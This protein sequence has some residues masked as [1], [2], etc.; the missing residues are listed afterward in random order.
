MGAIEDFLKIAAQP[1]FKGWSLV[2]EP[3]LGAKIDFFGQVLEYQLQTGNGIE[4]YSSI[5]RH[6]GWVVVFGVTEDDNVITLV[7]WKPGVNQASWEL[8]PGGIGKVDPG[9]TSQELLVKTQKAYLRETGFGGGTWEKLG[10][11]M[12]ETG[13]YRGAGPDD[14]GLPAHMYL[15]TGLTPMIEKRHPERNEIIQTLLVPIRE[16]WGVIDS[17]FFVEASALSCTMLAIRA[18]QKRGAL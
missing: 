10:H 14:H 4:K 1:R 15:A 16:F 6:F 5:I 18:I 13:K 8:P 2:G 3:K 17:G 9:I 12:I 11:V 7:Q